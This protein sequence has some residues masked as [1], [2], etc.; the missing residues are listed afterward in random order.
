MQLLTSSR[1]SQTFRQ[2]GIDRHLLQEL[3][4]CAPEELAKGEVGAIQRQRDQLIDAKSQST[5]ISPSMTKGFALWEV[6]SS[7]PCY[8]VYLPPIPSP[9]IIVHTQSGGHIRKLLEQREETYVVEKHNISIVPAY[10]PAYVAC[11][12]NIHTL[13]L[14][15]PPD[16]VKRIVRAMD[17]SIDPQLQLKACS[18]VRDTIAANLMSAITECASQSCGRTLAR[19][20]SALVLHLLDQ[21]GVTADKPAGSALDEQQLRFVHEYMLSK[22]GE[23]PNIDSVAAAL[24][25]GTA[26]FCR[27]FKAAT[28]LTPNEYYRKLRMQRAK[29]MIE[30]STKSLTHIAMDLGF[31]D[32]AHFSKTFHKQWNFPPSALR[33][34]SR[35]N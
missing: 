25:L 1:L 3:K 4:L 6:M 2:R 28:G 22:L 24:K 14:T 31:T 33:S 26:A 12:G 11:S 8:E 7:S 27:L 9:H 17:F 29:E 10:T 18:N 13:H 30:T 23:T 19:T 32:A 20:T 15:L 35:N 5:H 34:K 16:F 21:Y